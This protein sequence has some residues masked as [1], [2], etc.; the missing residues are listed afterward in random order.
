MSD[1]TCNGWT[2]YETWNCKLWIDNDGS[3]EYW[4]EQ[5]R[6]LVERDPDNAVYQ[7]SENMKDEFEENAPDL[8]ASFFSDILSAALHSVNWYEI[9]KHIV[10]DVK[11][12]A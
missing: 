9:A 2:N 7:L 4:E 11:E 12:N 6:E 10:E 1:N 8:G 5:A 3:N